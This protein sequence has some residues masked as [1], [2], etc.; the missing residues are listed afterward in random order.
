[1]HHLYG[2]RVSCENHNQ[3]IWTHAF[4]WIF[5]IISNVLHIRIV[6][7]CLWTP[8]PKVTYP[9]F[10]YTP[11]LHPC[12]KG[13]ST[14]VKKAPTIRC[15]KGEFVFVSKMDCFFAISI[16]KAQMLQDYQRWAWDS[17]L[18]RSGEVIRVVKASKTLFFQ[19]RSIHAWK[20][21]PGGECDHLF[22]NCWTA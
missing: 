3:S 10:F 6:V 2:S 9:P 13:V 14:L 17:V 5:E 7:F 20:S 4:T 16:S 18:C 11:I 15:V 19:S 21:W 22:C 12:I 8:G 1:M